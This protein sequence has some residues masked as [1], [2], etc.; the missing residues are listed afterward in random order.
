MTESKTVHVLLVEDN[1]VD[2][3]AVCRA[4]VKHKIANPI[5]V[6]SNGVEALRILR[7]EGC[8]PLPRP[9]LILL[10]IN[11]PRMNGL[12]LLREIR[13]DQ[14]LC[15][16]VVFVLTTSQSDEDKTASYGFNVAGYIVKSDVGAGF[17]R[18]VELL[19]RYWRIVELP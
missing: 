4:F 7:G 10:D 5:R 13:A 3:E 14:R 17:I 6:A 19:D 1:E 9:Y 16:A 15:E 12:E 11:L 18:L 8:A 2:V